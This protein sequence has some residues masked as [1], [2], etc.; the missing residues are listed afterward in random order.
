M[1]KT[2]A[3]VEN[4]SWDT[5]KELHSHAV[6]KSDKTIFVQLCGCI[7]LIQKVFGH[8]SHTQKYTKVITLYKNKHIKQNI[9]H[10]NK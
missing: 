3:F 4:T 1:M 5:R 10:K 9:S 6:I 8:S 2:Y 7:H